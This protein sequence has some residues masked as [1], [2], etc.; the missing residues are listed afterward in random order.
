MKHH[1][2]SF[3]SVCSGA[4]QRLSELKYDETFADFFRF[5]LSGK[6]RLWGSVVDEVFYVLWW[7][8]DHQVH[9]TSRD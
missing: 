5:R 6:K 7:D 3:E 9:P 1:H 2:E 4:Q 8:A